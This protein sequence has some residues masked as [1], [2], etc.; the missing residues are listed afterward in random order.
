MPKIYECPHGRI[1]KSMDNG[2]LE[3][4]NPEP[5]TSGIGCSYCLYQLL[6]LKKVDF[7]EVNNASKE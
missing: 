6:Q 1:Y 2:E 3:A 5:N 4:I 7:K